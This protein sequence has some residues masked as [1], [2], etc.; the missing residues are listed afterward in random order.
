M[1][2]AGSGRGGGEERDLKSGVVGCGLWVVGCGLW[3]VGC[4]LWVVGCG[5]WVVGCGLWVV[6]CGLW[7]VGCG[8]WVVGCGLWVVGCGL[9]VVGCG[10]W[11]VGRERGPFFLQF[12]LARFLKRTA[13]LLSSTPHH[14]TQRSEHKTTTKTWT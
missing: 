7:V 3:V 8:L 5:L 12:S 1:K 10:L 6:G 13:G 2:G 9:W 4:G 11:V 14:H